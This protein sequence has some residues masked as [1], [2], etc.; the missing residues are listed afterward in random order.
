[1]HR[2][3]AR[4]RA[5]SAFVA[6]GTLVYLL[7][8][9][10]AEL[11]GLSSVRAVTVAVLALGFAASASAV[12]PGFD[13]L[14]HGSKTYLGVTSLV[15]TGALAAGIFALVTESEGWLAALVATTLV[16]WVVSTIR[17]AI[18]NAPTGRPVVA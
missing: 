12:V 17:H 9:A 5:A 4:D 2:L 7:W 15:G 1:M 10:D 16:M 6:L 11:P 14:I 18:A 3:T 13:G 8:L